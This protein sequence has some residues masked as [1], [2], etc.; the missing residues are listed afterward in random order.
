MVKYD[1]SGKVALVTGAG[2]GMGLSTARAFAQAG[3]SVV[4]ADINDAADK[5]AKQLTAEGHQVIAIS[6]DV[7]HEEDVQRL[8]EGAVQIFGRLDFAF[9]NAGVMQPNVFAGEM[10]ADEWDRVQNVN[11]RGVWLCLKYEL[12]QMQKQGSGAIVNCSSVGGFVAT[13]GLGSYISSKHGVIGLTKTAAVEYA[14]KGIRVNAVCPGTIRTPMVEKMISGEGFDLGNFVRLIP[15]G[16][17]GRPEE[18][19]GAVLWLCSPDASY[20]IGHALP[21]D[22]GLLV[23]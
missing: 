12:Q 9:N 21:V 20:M 15:L 13:A 6:C 2:S 18:I 7:S 23:I 17:L 19:A 1:Y 16:R 14:S 10:T 22:G 5:A 4:L 3:A 8:I 11:L